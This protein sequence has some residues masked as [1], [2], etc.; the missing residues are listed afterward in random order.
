MHVYMQKQKQK[1][2]WQATHEA[3]WL[4]ETAGVV[5]LFSGLFVFFF[6]EHALLL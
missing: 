1:H 2:D 6:N 4:Q 5:Y 3:A